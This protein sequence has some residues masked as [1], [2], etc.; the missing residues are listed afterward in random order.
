MLASPADRVLE[1]A[2]SHDGSWASAPELHP[3]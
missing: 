2:I 3:V 1:E